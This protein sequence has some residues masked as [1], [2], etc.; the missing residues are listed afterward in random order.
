MA[1][2]FKFK[3]KNFISLNERV[4]FIRILFRWQ[5]SIWRLLWV[6]LL[7]F[8]IFYILITLSYR[9]VFVHFPSLKLGFEGFVR[10]TDKI[11]AIA[12]V[13]F[14]LGFFVSTILTR[15]WSFVANIPWMSSPSFLIHALVG[16][17]EQAFDTT[18][19]RIRRTLVRYMNLAWILAMMKLS[20]KMKSRFR[21]L[22]PVKFSDTDVKPRR[23]STS[24]VIDL[25]NNDVS[26]KKQF[27]QLITT[28]EAAIFLE[29]E[30]EEGKRVHKETKSRV[31]LV[32][33]AYNQ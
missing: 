32:D 14:L 26:V 10:Y 2:T 13:S 21:P 5:G 24:H 30:K 17:D 4:R 12:P 1:T 27:G 23:V 22:K 8:M 29:L 33:K 9:F 25:I 15:W 20:W 6:D 19:F 16:S 31:L 18:G 11:A 28:E 3:K 7:I